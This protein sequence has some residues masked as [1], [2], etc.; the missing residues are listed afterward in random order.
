MAARGAKG[1]SSLATIV[2]ERQDLVAEWQKRAGAR[3]TA[4]SQAPDKRDR[5]AEA[6]N[7]ARLIVGL[8]SAV[9]LVS[10]ACASAPVIDP[11]TRRSAL[12]HTPLPNHHVCS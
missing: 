1:D 8:K 12:A 2:R 4:V 5:A 9:G 7:A 11:F 10:R 3:T 6:A